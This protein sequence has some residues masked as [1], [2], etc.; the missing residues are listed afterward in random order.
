M[1][2][3]SVEFSDWFWQRGKSR[4]AFDKSCLQNAFLKFRFDGGRGTA[5]RSK[6]VTTSK[7]LKNKNKPYQPKGR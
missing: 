7:I 6:C 2:L 4:K 3:S 1:R 5:G